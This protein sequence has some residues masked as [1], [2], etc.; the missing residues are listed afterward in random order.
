MCRSALP[1]EAHELGRI[2]GFEHF[3]SVCAQEVAVAPAQGGLLLTEQN[4]RS[5]LDPPPSLGERPSSG[6]PDV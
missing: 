3:T 5:H 1:C 6:A 4:D 2:L